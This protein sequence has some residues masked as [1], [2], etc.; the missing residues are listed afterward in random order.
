MLS[1]EEEGQKYLEE[2]RREREE[3]RYR[4]EMKHHLKK[5]GVVFD[6]NASTATLEALCSKYL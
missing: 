2:K 5:D 1:Y 6:V 3:V 4:L